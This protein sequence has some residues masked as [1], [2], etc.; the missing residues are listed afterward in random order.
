MKRHCQRQA[1]YCSAFGA[2]FTA[3]L[4]R[5]LLNCIS[6]SRDLGQRIAN[7]P[8]DPRARGRQPPS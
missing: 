6:A 2:D 1:T 7:W 3:R 5:Q 8:S 4:L